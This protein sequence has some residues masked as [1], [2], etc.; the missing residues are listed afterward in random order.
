MSS[1]VIPAPACAGAGSAGTQGVGKRIALLGAESTGKSQLARELAAHLRDRGLRAT[2]V[3][4]VLREWCTR[5]GRLPRPE[6]QL[7]IAQEQERR[8]DEA[9]AASELAIADTS[10]LMVAIYAGMLFEDGD[11]YRFAIE[12]QRRYHATLLAGLDLPWVADGLHRDAAHSREEVDALLRSLLQR[13]HV[14]FQV[15]YGQGPQRLQ[16]AL[17]ALVSAGVLPQ[18]VVDRPD[19]AGSRRAWTWNCEKCSDP[20]CEHKLFTRLRASG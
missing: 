19:D 5:A 13:A 18:P 3:P 14:P 20:E 11:L 17:Q 6:E 9:A 12:R 7:A 1:P 10:A 16:A 8:V 2:A 4:E 15:V